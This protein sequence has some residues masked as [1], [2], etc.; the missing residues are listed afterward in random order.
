MRSR[1][2]AVSAATIALAFA[3]A[4]SLWWI[5]HY[6]WAGGFRT[7]TPHFAG[8]CRA[9]RGVTGPED[10]TIDPSS[11]MAYISAYD[12][13]A[14][15]RDDPAS[16][17]LYA[18]PLNSPNPQ[19]I[20]L[21]PDA[22]HDFRPHGISLYRG[23]DGEKKLFVVNHPQGGHSIE[24]FALEGAALEHESTIRGP[25]LTAPNDLVAVDPSR[26]YVTNSSRHDGGW[27]GWLEETFRMD[28]A[29]VLYYDGASFSAAIDGIGAPN[30]INVDHHGEEVYV[31]SAFDQAVYVYGREAV[32]GALTLEQSVPLGSRLDNIEV[33]GR[34][35]LWIAARAR[36]WDAPQ[37]SQ[38]FRI[39]L[40]PGAALEVDEVYLNDGDELA[41]ASVAAVYGRRLL[42]GSSR[43]RRFLDCRMDRAPVS[44]RVP[45]HTE[46]GP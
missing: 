31:A 2:L 40:A 11:G 36:F 5:D 21:T 24:R 37:P 46:H 43:E 29:N 9:V 30:G 13:G 14:A 26:F 39:T 12:R 27:L 18:Y 35:S 23:P 33:D 41:N 42:I 4:L 1:Q 16:G 15:A 19:L 34:G 22:A 6:R 28:L 17:A 38:V 32:S 44:P 7:I 45:A 25:A 10:I 8:S 3:L 20:N